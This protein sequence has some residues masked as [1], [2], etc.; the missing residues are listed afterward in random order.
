M[1]GKGISLEFPVDTVGIIFDS[2]QKLVSG[3]F[4]AVTRR[5]FNKEP[6]AFLFG[7]SGTFIKRFYIGDGIEH[8]LADPS[9]GFWV[10][11]FD[12][13][14]F[15]GGEDDLGPEGLVKFDENGTPVFRFVSD[16][17]TGE[18]IDD[19]YAL[20]IDQ[21]GS[22]WLCP[23]SRFYVA[24]IT[25]N[26]VEVVLEA[27]PIRGSHG[28]AISPKENVIMFSG[29]Y[30]KLREFSLLNFNKGSMRKINFFDDKGVPIKAEGNFSKS[31][32]DS[33]Y[34]LWDQKVYVLSLS[35]A[36]ENIGPW[37]KENSYSISLAI[38]KVNAVEK[39]SEKI[40]WVIKKAKDKK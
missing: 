39:A 15:N 27:S 34:V 11:Y 1:E 17:T 26:C 13:G 37:N 38:E 7:K 5:S 36:L 23:Y 22:V 20:N 2:L 21:K 3:K 35:I 25:G 30:K 40:N 12:E 9:G 4:L 18:Y 10:G 24:K 28:L 29:T 8:V 6:N 33:I 14:V 19:L 16:G 31:F 32:Q